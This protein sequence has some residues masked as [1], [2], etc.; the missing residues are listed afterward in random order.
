MPKEHEGLEALNQIEST[1][2][3]EAVRGIPSLSDLC[4]QY[5][6][7][8]PMVEKALGL[9]EII[10]IYGTK[11]AVAMRFLMKVA[12]VACPATQGKG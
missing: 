5:K 4:Q 2:Q 3:E 1:L 8:K 11:I 7:V 12:D 10:P 6:K 9:I